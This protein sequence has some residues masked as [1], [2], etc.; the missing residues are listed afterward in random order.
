MMISLYLGLLSS[1]FLQLYLKPAFSS[2]L[3]SYLYP[4]YI[5]STCSVFLCSSAVYCSVCLAMHSCLLLCMR[6]SYLRVTFS[7][8]LHKFLISTVSLHKSSLAVLFGYSIRSQFILGYF[9]DRWPYFAGKLSWDITTSVPIGQASVRRWSVVETSRPAALVDLQSPRRPPVAT[10]YCRRS[11][12]WY[13]RP[14]TLEQ[15]TCRR[16]VCPITHN[17]SS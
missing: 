2:F 17:I 12:V 15:S 4:V 11:L 3:H 1:I 5:W 13:C 14:A 9:W 16:P 10:C 6:A 8:Y 7:F